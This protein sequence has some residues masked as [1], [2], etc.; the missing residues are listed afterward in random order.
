MSE[1]LKQ[2]NRNYFW[3]INQKDFDEAKSKRLVIERVIN[4]GNLKEIKLVWGHYGEHEFRKTICNLNYIDPK[5]LN[6]F[7]ILFKIPKSD[8]KCYTRKQL[9]PHPWTY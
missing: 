8:F 5:T 3:D 9:N 6:F 1:L 2:L 4:F 7:S